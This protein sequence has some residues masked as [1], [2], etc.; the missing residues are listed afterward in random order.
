MNHLRAAWAARV[1]GGAVT[2]ERFNDGGML[3]RPVV[4][5]GW[6][7]RRLSNFAID[8]D[9]QQV[10]VAQVYDPTPDDPR[11]VIGWINIRPEHRRKGVATEALRLLRQHYG[12][13]VSYE[14]LTDLGEKWWRSL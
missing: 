8:L 2:V 12:T 7:A 10:G 4:G 11:A 9:G 5:A 3:G 6:D 1:A 14:S 13:T